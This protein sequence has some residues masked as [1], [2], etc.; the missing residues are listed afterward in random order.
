MQRII[1]EKSGKSKN[2]Q[3]KQG[4]QHKEA[5]DL[6]EEINDVILNHLIIEDQN[7]ANKDQQEVL[8]TSILNHFV[9]EA[10]TTQEIPE[11]SDSITKICPKSEKCSEK[12]GYPVET[13]DS[14][15]YCNYSHLTE[16]S[17]T[18]TA[19]HAYSSLQGSPIFQEN[20]QFERIAPVKSDLDIEKCIVPIKS[21]L[22]LRMTRNLISCP[23]S[24]C[25]KVAFLSELTMHIKM[26][27]KKIPLESICPGQHRNVFLDPKLEHLNIFRGQMLYLVTNKIHSLGF[28]T[29]QNYLPTILMSTKFN[30]VSLV[31]GENKGRSRLRQ[32]TMFFLSGPCT[33][34]IPVS[35][36]LV[37]WGS[38]TSL[39]VVYSGEMQPIDVNLSY[40]KIYKSGKVLLLSQRQINEL[41]NRGKNMILVQ[42]VIN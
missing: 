16:I 27:H 24:G 20:T 29:F 15:S 38:D 41:S 1:K 37:I 36:G 32:F 3:V 39:R 26:D 7:S 5:T 10:P 40:E 23:I 9:L 22:G 18:I 25:H 13:E 19:Y 2:D 33:E 17:S 8:E 31:H 12:T 42:I 34:E 14:A 28:Q 35:Y 6:N 4:A 11:N 30:L 21:A